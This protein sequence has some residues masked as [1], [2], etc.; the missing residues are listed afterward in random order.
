MANLVSHLQAYF[1]PTHST[2]QGSQV[3]I[4]SAALW[5][6]PSVFAVFAAQTF[7]KLLYE[8]HNQYLLTIFGQYGS[9]TIFMG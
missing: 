8:G 3:G 1:A 2:F 6:L 7:A 9:M 5:L 4:A